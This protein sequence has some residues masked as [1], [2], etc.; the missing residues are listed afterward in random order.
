MKLRHLYAALA[1]IALFGLLILMRVTLANSNLQGDQT[2]DLPAAPLTTQAELDAFLDEFNFRSGYYLSSHTGGQTI[3]RNSTQSVCL[4]NM[5]SIFCLTELYRQKH[6]ENLDLNKSVLIKEGDEA[7]LYQAAQRMLFASDN[8]AMHALAEYLG[9]DQISKL[10]RKLD[11]TTVNTPVL[12]SHKT[13]TVALNRRLFGRREAKPG[14]EQ[15]GSAQGISQFYQLLTQ[16][17][18]LSPAINA[19]LITFLE[20]QPRDFSLHLQDSH[21]LFGQGGNLHW[22]R[23]QKHFSMMGWAGYTSLSSGQPVTLCV[24]GEWFPR[25]V[26]PTEQAR[27]MQFVVDSLVTIAEQ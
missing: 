15:H 19:E 26:K 5:A 8:D 4:A 3:E 12:P 27:I 20:S 13:L 17:K 6:E 24:W 22:T 18:V 2:V 9:R 21:Q 11:I 10:L 14:L 1:G 23:P 7:T 16:G 25:N